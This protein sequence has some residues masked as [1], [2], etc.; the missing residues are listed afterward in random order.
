MTAKRPGRRPGASNTRED[1]LASARKLFSVNGIDKTSMRSIA[2]DAG[3][4]PALIHHYFGTKVDLF[5]Q[6]I[7]LPGDPELLLE[8]LRQT[9]VEDIGHMLPKL[10]VTVWDSELGVGMLAT[11]RSQLSGADTGLIR[12]F[13]RDIVLKALGDR[14]DNPVGSGVMRAG[15]A[16]TQM[17]GIVMARYIIKLEPIASLS[18]DEIADMV[19]PNIQRYLT[20]DLPLPS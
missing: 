2:A 1:I 15:F 18:A 10:L 11:V 6:A 8:P 13:F 4:D 7:K 3:V 12:A 16:A 14:V 17:L 19:G 5:R 9:K 20:G